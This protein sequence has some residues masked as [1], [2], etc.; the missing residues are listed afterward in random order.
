MLLFNVSYKILAGILLHQTLY[1]V[2]QVSG[3][4]LT[5][6]GIKPGPLVT[7]LTVFVDSAID[8]EETIRCRSAVYLSSPTGCISTKAWPVTD[9]PP[10]VPS[11]DP[12]PSYLIF[13]ESIT[14]S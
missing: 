12:K 8:R 7:D 11:T 6:L 13:V 14:I 5:A 9:R 4:V 3:P 2:Y 10:S 1:W